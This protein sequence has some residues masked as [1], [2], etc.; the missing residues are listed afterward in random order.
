MN[1]GSDQQPIKGGCV[2]VGRLCQSEAL[3]AYFGNDSPVGCPGAQEVVD[4]VSEP[5]VIGLTDDDSLNGVVLDDPFG[6]LT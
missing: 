4:A 3:T 1:S 5:D 6:L 2:S